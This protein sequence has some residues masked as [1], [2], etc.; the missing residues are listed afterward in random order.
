MK[1]LIVIILCSEFY[2][3]TSVKLV[4]LAI[5]VFDTILSYFYPGTC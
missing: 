5:S 3:D 2:F 4:V 1:F